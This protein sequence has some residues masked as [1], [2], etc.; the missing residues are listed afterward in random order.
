MDITPVLTE[1]QQLIQRYGDRKFTISGTEYEGSV[2]I[3]PEKTDNW[4][5]SDFSALNETMLVTMLGDMPDME[6][7][8][9]GS[10]EAMQMLSAELRQFMRS[11]GVAVEVMD[12]G[13]ACRTFN[14][15]LGEGRRVA[16]A[17][18]AV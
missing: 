10:G 13:A 16:A 5:A 2:I 11:K 6:I 12:T 17:L 15:L 8:L 9:L 18:I 3:L 14:I 1:T 4:P 7:L